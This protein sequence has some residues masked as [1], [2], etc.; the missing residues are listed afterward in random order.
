MEDKRAFMWVE[1][2][3]YSNLAAAKPLK[4]FQADTAPVANEPQAKGMSMF[5]GR[6]TLNQGGN[7]RGAAR[8][9]PGRE[10]QKKRQTRP[11]A[12]YRTILLAGRVAQRVL[13]EIVLRDGREVIAAR[14]RQLIL[15]QQIFQHGADAGLAALA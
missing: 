5:G 7:C 1:I 14:P 6:T 12:P 11:G 8:L 10:A 13:R 4:L 3:A 15:G 9:R 2:F